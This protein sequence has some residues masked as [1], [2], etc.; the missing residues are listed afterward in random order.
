MIFGDPLFCHVKFT[1]TMLCL[2]MIFRAI[3]GLILC[4]EKSDAYSSIFCVSKKKLEKLFNYI[5]PKVFIDGGKKFNNSLL[6][7]HFRDN[8]IVF[9][10]SSHNTQAQNSVLKLKHRHVIEMTHSML[11]QFDF[12]SDFWV[13]ASNNAIYTI[14]R[15]HSSIV[16][17]V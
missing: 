9:Q 13:D 1:N 6:L 16:R 4:V 3:H 11:T 17:G 5:I 15:L 8:G 12:L 10:K 7:Q 14:S 2:L